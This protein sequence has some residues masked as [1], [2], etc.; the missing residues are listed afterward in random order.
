M[1]GTEPGR[2]DACGGTTPVGPGW[3][4]YIAGQR[5][6]A[7]SQLNA[8]SGSTT[9]AHHQHPAWRFS[10]I[11]G[12][13][14]ARSAAL[15]YIPFSSNTRPAPSRAGTRPAAARRSCSPSSGVTTSPRAAAH[16]PT[17]TGFNGS[18]QR[19]GRP[20][21]PRSP[22][23]VSTSCRRHRSPNAAGVY[24]GR[25]RPSLG[26][27]PTPASHQARTTSVEPTRR[28]TSAEPSMVR[29]SSAR[30]ELDRSTTPEAVRACPTTTWG[31]RISTSHT[32]RTARPGPSVL[33]RPAP[34]SARVFR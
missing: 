23:R 19:R 24:G 8:S 20:A 14:G 18:L 22:G 2:D 21:P 31:F 17:W 25:A 13:A 33:I 15:S 6:P 5:M 1:P 12:G 30:Y 4:S 28:A 9:S 11:L 16:V 34:T 27:T 3:S 29:A 10:F 7:P 26:Q 32:P